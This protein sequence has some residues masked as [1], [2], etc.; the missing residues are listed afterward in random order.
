MSEW[1]TNGRESVVI[2]TYFDIGL[3][4]QLTIDGVSNRYIS[5]VLRAPSSSGRRSRIE[6][7]AR[8]ISVMS[9]R[10]HVTRHVLDVA[11]DYN[12]ILIMPRLSDDDND[13]F[14]TNLIP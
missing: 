2:L 3:G 5:H 14:L 11:R 7:E 10:S 8:S 13:Y 9:E 1:D 6:V 4:G 12:R